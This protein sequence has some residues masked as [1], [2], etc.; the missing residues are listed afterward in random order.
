MTVMASEVNVVLHKGLWPRGLVST[1]L[2]EADEQALQHY[3]E[4]EARIPEET[5]TIELGDGAA[6]AVG[7]DVRTEN[8]GTTEP[9]IEGAEPERTA[10]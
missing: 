5:V 10:G 2:T 8:T 1:D 7:T 4:A 3:A 6:T 9:H